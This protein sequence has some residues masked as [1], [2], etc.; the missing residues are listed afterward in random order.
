MD[1]KTKISINRYLGGLGRGSKSQS[2][3]REVERV[4]CDCNG[5]TQECM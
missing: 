4:R 3:L 2:L 1:D 5:R